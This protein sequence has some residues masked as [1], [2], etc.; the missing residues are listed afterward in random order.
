M[1]LTGWYQGTAER[2]D[3][4]RAEHP[5]DFPSFP[6]P[7]FGVYLKGQSSSEFLSFSDTSTEKYF[8]ECEKGEI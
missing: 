2:E 5:K 8:S 1:S 7:L 6:L 3:A 4:E